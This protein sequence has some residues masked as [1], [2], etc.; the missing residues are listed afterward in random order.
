MPH[1]SHPLFAQPA[2]ADDAVLFRSSGTSAAVA[3]EA[4]WRYG[5]AVDVYSV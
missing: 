1:R 3:P 5:R 4:L 2:C